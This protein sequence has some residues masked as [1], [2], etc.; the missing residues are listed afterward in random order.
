[1]TRMNRWLLRGGRTVALA[2][3]YGWIFMMAVI[4][5]E[6]IP[7]PE[8]VTPSPMPTA[9]VEAWRSLLLLAPVLFL[10]PNGFVGAKPW[11]GWAGALVRATFGA[12]WF[13]HGLWVFA[14][15]AYRPGPLGTWWL[16]EAWWFTGLLA[17]AAFLLLL[18]HELRLT[19]DKGQGSN[20]AAGADSTES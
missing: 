5:A 9:E 2:G 15:A 3:M 8:A 20:A 16:P 17:F 18:P 1:M 13:N 10:T 11:A 7:E 12:L 6:G 19:P 14:H 4:V